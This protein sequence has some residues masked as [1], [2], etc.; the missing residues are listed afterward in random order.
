MRLE[1]GSEQEAAH[2]RA[3]MEHLSKRGITITSSRRTP[4]GMLVHEAEFR[5]GAVIYSKLP[6]EPKDE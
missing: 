3:V 1:P 6:A 5:P 4:S 2:H